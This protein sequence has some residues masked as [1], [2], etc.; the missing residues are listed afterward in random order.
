[1]G[2]MTVIHREN[3]EFAVLVRDHVVYLDQPYSAGGMDGGPTP[4]E[5]F[6]ASLAACA[7]HY[8]RRYLQWRGLP[9]DGLEVTAD[10]AMSAGTPARVSRIGLRLRPP[11]SLADGDAE[12]MR[13][14]AEGCTVHNTL[15][16]PPRIGLEVVTEARAA[17]PAA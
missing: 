14:A 10:Y 16:D 8:A 13:R 7:A 17:E 1:M 3:S 12:E 4:V 6:V 2:E 11:I 9:A 15:V 5:L